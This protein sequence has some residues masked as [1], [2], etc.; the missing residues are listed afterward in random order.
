MNNVISFEKAKAKR[1]PRI[2][3]IHIELAWVEPKIWRRILVPETI[4]LGKLHE[5][6]Q[7]V[8]F[9]NDTH[10][11]EYDFHGER[12]GTPDPLFDVNPVKADT[13]VQLKT[14][15]GKLVS[16]NYLYDFGDHWL[17][18]MTVEERFPP[19][20]AFS[21]K[22]VCLDGANAAPPD[23]VGGAPGFESFK[24]IMSDPKHPEYRAMKQWFG[25]KYVAT[26][27][28]PTAINKGLLKINL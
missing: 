10:L 27:F 16:F 17:H 13:Q 5:V 20:S 9:W 24:E 21:H 12:Y 15:L 23:D 19:D 22:A 3:Q 7:N 2:L 11:H 1:A 8:F 14:A 6:V 25:G 26:Q 28:D 4:T 18:V